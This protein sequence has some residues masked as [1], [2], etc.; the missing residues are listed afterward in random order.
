MVMAD[1]TDISKV[2]LKIPINTEL[3]IYITLE[4]S[5]S[6]ANKNVL[7]RKLGNCSNRGH[8]I[9]AFEL[10]KASSFIFILKIPAENVNFFNKVRSR[11]DEPK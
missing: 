2:S 9:T 5:V 11:R 3:C 7:I 10:Y 4:S 8:N 6:T 1:L